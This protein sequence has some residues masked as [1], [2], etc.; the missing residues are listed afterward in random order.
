MTSTSS[1]N[2]TTENRPQK[3]EKDQPIALSKSITLT[4]R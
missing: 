2:K 3:Q 1:S 4:D